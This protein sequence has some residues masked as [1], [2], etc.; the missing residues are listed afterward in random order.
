MR[1][2]LSSWFIVA[3]SA[4]AVAAVCV[5]ICVVGEVTMVMVVMSLSPC[6]PIYAVRVYGMRY[7]RTEN[8]C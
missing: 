7:I 3:F 8:L 1:Y 2:A 5:D 4:M 6:C